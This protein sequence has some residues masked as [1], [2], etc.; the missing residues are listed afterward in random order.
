MLSMTVNIASMMHFNASHSHTQPCLAAYCIWCN[1]SMIQA[2]YQALQ[3]SVSLESVPEIQSIKGT[4]LGSALDSPLTFILCTLCP[5]IHTPQSYQV[6][7]SLQGV[8]NKSNDLHDVTHRCHTHQ[9]G[10]LVRPSSTCESRQ[11]SNNIVKAGCI[12]VQQ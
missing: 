9:H 12:A 3:I 11:Q 5:C 4:V 6:E 1:T 7:R 8:L 2:F 10:L